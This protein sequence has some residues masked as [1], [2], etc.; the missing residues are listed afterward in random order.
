VGPKKP[1]ATQ[2]KGETEKIKSLQ[3][4]R[5]VKKVFKSAQ[6]NLTSR[7]KTDEKQNKTEECLAHQKQ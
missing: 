7:E 4:A 6:E 5:H 3:R 2:L 1:E